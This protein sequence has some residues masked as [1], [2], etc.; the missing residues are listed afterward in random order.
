MINELKDH[1]DMILKIVHCIENIKSSVNTNMNDTMELKNNLNSFFGE[2]Y[3]CK[4]I[5]ITD[6]DKPQFGCVVMPLFSDLVD[7]ILVSGDTDIKFNT[8]SLEL[9]R[10]VLNDP[11]IYSREIVAII[12][13]NIYYMINNTTIISRLRSE[14][15]NYFL[16]TGTQLVIKDSIQYKKI[17][18]LGLAD[19]LIKL[20]SCLY[21]EADTI[22]DPYMRSIGL[23]SELFSGINKVFN[24]IPT[25]SNSI[26]NINSVKI[27]ILHW[28]F[29]LYNNVDTE[30]IPSIRIL[31]RAKELNP[32]VLYGMKIDAAIEALHKIDTDTLINETVSEYFKSTLKNDKHISKIIKEG[33]SYIE[34]NLYYNMYIMGNNKSYPK[35]ELLKNIN[36]QLGFLEN[37]VNDPEISD[38]KKEK[39]FSLYERYMDIR[40]ML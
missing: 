32:S 30:R 21:L 20:S 36:V 33:L 34:E 19:T 29:R 12:I 38:Y 26:L 40:E 18:E 11:A 7:S 31:Q 5:I 22:S 17:L 28:C 2:G 16:T 8:Y 39:A 14:V 15:D 27:I 3:N 25:L 4:E 23:D 37:F 35:N 1:E 10:K 9:D 6:H 24:Q 13:Y